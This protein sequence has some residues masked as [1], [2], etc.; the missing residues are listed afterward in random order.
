MFFS[1]FCFGVSEQHL[2]RNF[3]MRKIRGVNLLDGSNLADLA[4]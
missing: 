2:M 4:R 3:S 1:D